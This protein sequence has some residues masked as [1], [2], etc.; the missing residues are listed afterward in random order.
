MSMS[1]HVLWQRGARIDSPSLAATLKDLGFE[2]DLM[3]E[4][5]GAEGFW[6]ADIA[7]FRTG[8]EVYMGPIDNFVEDYPDLA[9]SLQGRDTEAVFIWHSDFAQAG[10][11]MLVS[12]ALAKVTQGLIYE[13]QDGEFYPIERAVQAAQELLE[14]ARK[15]GYEDR[16]D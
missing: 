14:V 13:A 15:E 1:V 2:A 4:L 11:A 12:A 3:H 7:G 5:D 10:A 8:F 9:S 6:P 16:E